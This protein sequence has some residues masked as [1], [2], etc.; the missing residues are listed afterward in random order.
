MDLKVITYIQ[1]NIY[2]LNAM[3]DMHL[4]IL[5]ILYSYLTFSYSFKVLNGRDYLSMIVKAQR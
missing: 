3:W 2:R 5:C 4:L 1:L